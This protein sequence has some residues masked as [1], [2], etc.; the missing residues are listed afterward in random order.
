MAVVLVLLHLKLLDFMWYNLPAGR[1]KEGDSDASSHSI[2]NP[3]LY[4]KDKLELREKEIV[5]KILATEMK[6]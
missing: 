4:M 5:T 3:R 6:Y 2:I 1:S